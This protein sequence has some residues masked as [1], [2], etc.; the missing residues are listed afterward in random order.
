MFRCFVADD[1]GKLVG[2]AM[3]FFNYSAWEGVNVYLEDL[4][5]TPSHRQL[6]IG[7]RLMQKV[8]QV[9]VDRKCNRLDWVC[10]GWNKRAIDFYKSKG[11]VNL[12][13][14]E[15][16]NVFRLCGEKL[17]AFANDA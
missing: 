1:R 5:V 7:T 4:Y 13:S 15:N 14:D 16:W 17:S 2:H 8:A 12:T 11:A 3:F 10:L 6:G 9:A